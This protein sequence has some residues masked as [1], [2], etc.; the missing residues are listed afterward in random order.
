MTL[1]SHEPI[2]EWFG[3][4]YASYLV[5]R[6]S[7]LQSA[8]VPLQ[9]RLVE[10]LNELYDLFGSEALEGDFTVQMRNDAGRFVED[11]YADYER[12]RRRILFA[13]KEPKQ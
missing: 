8:P 13:I 11:P 12:G 1:D 10:V 7:M 9:R 5:L 3:L 6:R 4:T 2:H